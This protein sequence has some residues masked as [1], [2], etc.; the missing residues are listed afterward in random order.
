LSTEIQK[1]G[2]ILSKAQAE[3]K[4]ADAGASTD[5]GAENSENVKDAEFKEKK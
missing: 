3:A 4:P 2:E 5:K 1:I